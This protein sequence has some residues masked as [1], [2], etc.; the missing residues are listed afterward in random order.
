[1]VTLATEGDM[2]D[3]VDK[4]TLVNDVTAVI[5]EQAAMLEEYFNIRIDVTKEAIC[6][7]P[8]LLMDYNPLMAKLPLFLMRLGT[9]VCFLLIVDKL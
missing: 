6:T 2:V 8:I 1:M 4:A 9:E 3:D 7:L 5:L